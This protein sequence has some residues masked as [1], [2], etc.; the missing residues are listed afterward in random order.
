MKNKTL[1]MAGNIEKAGSC[2]F[3]FYIY[4]KNSEIIRR[5]LAYTF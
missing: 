1:P 5:L 3:P 4:A 2:H